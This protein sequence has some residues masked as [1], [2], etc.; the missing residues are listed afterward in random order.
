MMVAGIGCRRGA[1]AEEIMAVIAEA[2]DRLGLPRAS[3]GA[4]A[5]LAEK[6]EEPGL[7]EASRRLSLPLVACSREAMRAAADRIVTFSARAEAA[8]GLPSIAEGAALA[9]AGPTAWLLL[10]RISGSRT[11]CAIAQGQTP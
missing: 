11:T 5:T 2:L 1:S 3:L 10:A 4:L 8:T 7:Y 6:A 9:A